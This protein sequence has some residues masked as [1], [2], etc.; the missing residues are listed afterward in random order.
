M[1]R[2]NSIIKGPF[3]P[4]PVEVKKI[5]H[6]GEYVHIIGVTVYSKTHIDQLLPKE[7]FDELEVEGFLMDFS[8]PADETFLFLEGMRYK[9][10]SLFDPLLAVNV[11][12]IDPLPFQIDAVYGYILKLPKIRFLL[13]DDPGAGKTIMAG[14]VLKELKLRGLVSRILIIVPG[15]LKDQWIRE[16]KEKFHEHF[17]VIDRGTF[18]AHYGENP[19]ERENQ[20]ITSMD[21]AK[22]KDILPSLQ[23]VEWD[24]VIVD[25]AHKM[26]AYRYGDKLT[27]TERYRLGEVVSKN[28]THLLFL[29]ATPHK[30]DPENFRLFLDLLSPGFFS[31]TE[32]I[33]ES[34][35][36]RDNPLFIRRMKEDLRDFDGKPIFTNRY[37]ITIKFTLSDKE[38]DLYNELSKYVITQYNLALQRIQEK[39]R[40]NIAFALLILQRRLASSTYALLK[41]LKRRIQRLEELLKEPGLPEEEGITVDLEEV[42]DY[43]EKERW[44]FEKKWETLSIAADKEELRKEIEV[45]SELIKRSEEIIREEC[46]VKLQELKKAVEEGF[47]KIREM[48]GNEKILIF[49]ESRDTMEYLVKKLREWG[50]SVNYMHGGMNLDERILAEKIF[51]DKTQIMVSTEAGGEGI[52]LQF[53]HLMINYDIPWNPNR[54]EQR[55]GRI[56]RYGQQK[57]VY[58]FN[59]VA[60][61]TREG[62]VLAKLLDKLDEIRRALGSDKVF[63][64]IGDV[65]YGKSLYQ[66]ILEAVANTRDIDEIIKEIDVQV[67][68]SY[69]NRVKEALGESL[70]TRFI[71]YTRIRDMAEKAKEYR[72]IPEYVEAF[73]KK[74][75]E[76]AGGKLRIRKDGFIAIE[77]VPYEIRKIAQEVNFKNRYGLVLKEYHKVTFDKDVAFKNPDAEFISFGH[78]LFEALLEWINR[79]FSQKIKRGAIFEDPSCTFNGIIWFYEGEVTDGKGEIAGRKLIAIYDD[80]NLLEEI[81]P[82]ILWDLVPVKENNNLTLTM[83][84]KFLR[85]KA[86][87]YA[88]AAVERYRMEILEERKRQAEVKRKYGVRS[89]EYLIS[90]LD[91][92]LAA[93]YERQAEGEKVD[94]VIM[95]KA[96]KKREYENAL[97][98]LKEE[99][100]REL[101]LTI[102][103]PKFL[104]AIYVMPS[105][106]AADMTPN[107]D[108]EK[109]GMQI[110]IEFE[111]RSGRVPEDVSK[112]NLGFDIRSKGRNEVR[113]IEV[114][115]RADVGPVALT[116]NELFKAKR[117]KD[118]YWLYVVFKAVKEPELIIINNPAEKLRC[119]EKVEVVRFIVPLEELINKGERIDYGKI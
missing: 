56:H 101:S 109:I 87:R 19:W 21:F 117:F 99:I 33:N 9:F 49:T 3:W 45:I 86:D 73:F 42:E 71:D 23:S 35:K 77:S 24:L 25:E 97:S 67:D 29:T 1:I 82:V 74:A 119:E 34:L 6:I 61:N 40:R 17:T 37:P 110:A 91:A 59:L 30:G 46:E 55:M 102:S 94:I 75:F 22:Q 10:A 85:E 28:T 70:A 4:E 88:I 80:G 58:I 107:E 36:S 44:E 7:D 98:N 57:D 108:V 113:Y 96:E 83:L 5:E 89:L 72:L 116:P 2:E 93:L 63:D 32:L 38:M 31:T 65:F 78:P 112:E 50:Y 118:Q 114:K 16:L 95:N 62:K 103:M 26:A 106:K 15:H 53:C 54:L 12:K 69:I 100:E 105:L 18:F 60:E 52:N 27:K 47:R 92:D 11:S 41:S 43:E 64:V 90:E 39:R 66:L 111:K 84:N 48:G 76:K 20:V 68:E 14:L 51:R 13:A 81:N 8:A 104:G 115:A 79:S